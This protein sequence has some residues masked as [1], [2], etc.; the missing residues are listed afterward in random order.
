M[1]RFSLHHLAL[2]TLGALA[3]SCVSPPVHQGPTPDERLEALL[4]ASEEPD[5]ELARQLRALSLQAPGHVPT[6]I[7]DAALSMETGRDER[8]VSLL[9]LALKAEPDNVEAVQLAVQLAARSGDLAGAHRR[10]EAALRTRP[11]APGLHEAYAALLYV[12]GEYPEAVAALDRADALSGGMTW[13]SHYHR[14]LIAEDLGELEAAE[15]HYESCTLDAPDFEPAAR[16]LR[17]IRAQQASE[18]D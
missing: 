4:S 16:R 6:L 13:R 5:L 17:W 11:D 8:A 9:D 1:S 15:G 3:A 14:G 18:K 2:P 10:V 12:E 7:A